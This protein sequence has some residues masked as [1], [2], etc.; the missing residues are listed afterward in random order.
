VI[1]LLLILSFPGN[2]KW[3]TLRVA[4]FRIYSS[5]DDARTQKIAGEL[6]KIRPAVAKIT[7]LDIRPVLPTRVLIFRDEKRLGPIRDAALERPAPTAAGIFLGGQNANYILL[8]ADTESGVDRIVYRELTNQ[9]IGNTAPG[10]PLWLREGLAEYFSTFTAKGDDIYLGAL[11]PYHVNYLREHPL[12]PLRKLVAMNESS[13]EARAQWWAVIHYLLNGTDKWGAEVALLFAGES[14]GEAVY[15]DLDRELQQYVRRHVFGYRKDSLSAPE[16]I[17]SPKP[18]S[19]DT[20]LYAIGDVLAHTGESNRDD[21]EAFLREA[22]RLNPSL[23]EAHA[24]LGVIHD[25]RKR[26]AEADAAYEKAIQLGS[27]DPNVYILYGGALLERGDPARARGLFRRATELDPAAA[28]AWTGLGATLMDSEADRAAAIAAL[29]TSLA[30]VAAQQD[31][32]FY[33]VQLYA[34]AGRAADA[35]RLFETT[36][37]RASDPEVVRRARENVLVAEVMQA[38][39]LMETGKVEESATLLRAVHKITTSDRLKKHSESLLAELDRQLAFQKQAGIYDAAVEKAKAGHYADAV[40]MV[41]EILPQIVD[42][43]LRGMVQ[44]FRDETAKK[45]KK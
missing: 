39:A 45:I 44:R 36:L 10:F 4:E 8:R 32:A 30:L 25:L 2:E 15:E 7:R 28:R 12:P 17:P 41:D 33:L 14:L 26:R 9:L 5:A 31:A 37:A 23:A 34:R 35:R 29:E 18:A 6:A 38:Q 22:L 1:L 20:V 13:A 16:S 40:A 27:T 43:D 19:R 42:K 21:A 24:S 3:T 11:V